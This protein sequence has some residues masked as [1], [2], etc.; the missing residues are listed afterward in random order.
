MAQAVMVKK[1]QAIFYFRYADAIEAG[2]IMLERRIA[3]GPGQTCKFFTPNR[4]DKAT[5]AQRY[6]AL[7]YLPQYRIGPIREDEVPDFD[8]VPLRFVSPANGQPGGGQEAATSETVYLF[9]CSRLT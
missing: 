2:L 8:R 4:F 1:A 3:P 6:L 5:D 7:S 9:N